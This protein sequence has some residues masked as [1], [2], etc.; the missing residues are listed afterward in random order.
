MQRPAVACQH[1]VALAQAERR[2]HVAAAVAQA[3]I[4]MLAPLSATDQKTF[5]RL[6]AQLVAGHES[7]DPER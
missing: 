2:A 3:Q 5:M 7:T 6:L 1:D 4:N